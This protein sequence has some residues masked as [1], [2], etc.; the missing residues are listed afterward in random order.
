[1]LLPRIKA[2]KLILS[3]V[4]IHNVVNITKS[5]LDV[6]TEACVHLHTF[7]VPTLPHR[8]MTYLLYTSLCPALLDLQAYL[9]NSFKGTVFYA[10]GRHQ[11]GRCQTEKMPKRRIYNPPSLASGFPVL[12][13][14]PPSAM[15]EETYA[16]RTSAGQR[17]LYAG[18]RDVLYKSVLTYTSAISMRGDIRQAGF[19]GTTRARKSFQAGIGKL[20]RGIGG[21]Q[22][23]T[24]AD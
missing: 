22:N 20:Q 23:K 6:R 10:L 13:F 17:R 8:P 16:S 5:A 7:A 2:L 21:V 1:M 9:N 14:P 4:H 19:L 18:R 12:F 3:R 11:E 24:L 15:A